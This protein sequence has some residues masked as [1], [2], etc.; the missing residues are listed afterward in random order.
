[1]S[2]ADVIA[3]KFAAINWETLDVSAVCAF[4]DQIG[5]PPGERALLVAP[6]DPALRDAWRRRCIADLSA[7]QARG[8]PT[9]GA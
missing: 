1:M 9:C 6:V 2:D 4:Y 8:C 3:A 7:M 5:R